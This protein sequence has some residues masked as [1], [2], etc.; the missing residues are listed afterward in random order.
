MI[1]EFFSPFFLLLFSVKYPFSSS[2]IL[3]VS[4]AMA[5]LFTVT[6]F[7]GF[8]CPCIY[9]VCHLSKGW[10]RSQMLFYF[11]QLH[12]ATPGESKTIS[13]PPERFSPFKVL[14]ASPLALLP[15]GLTCFISAGRSQK[16]ILA[17]LGSALLI[18]EELINLQN[19]LASRA[20]HSLIGIVPAVCGEMSVWQLKSLFLFTPFWPEVNFDRQTF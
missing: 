12:P 6:L 15:V 14:S 16:P 5:C 4:G 10:N 2:P 17:R 11:W 20:A 3:W 9:P 13:R 19:L 1:E 8:N 7:W 18:A